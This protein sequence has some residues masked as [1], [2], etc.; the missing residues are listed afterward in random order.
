MIEQDAIKLLKQIHEKGVNCTLTRAPQGSLSFIFT[1][2]SGFAYCVM[3]LDKP[4]D[5][6]NLVEKLYT[7]FD[8]RNEF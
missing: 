8:E 4:Y 3:N 1:D 5:I 7:I 6:R 2:R